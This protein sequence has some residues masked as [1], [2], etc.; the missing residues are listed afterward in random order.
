MIED[1]LECD[2]ASFVDFIE[3]SDNI[4]VCVT[5]TA[6]SRMGPLASDDTGLGNTSSVDIGGPSTESSGSPLKAAQHPN[7]GVA[8]KHP[9]TTERV[10]SQ[11]S[12]RNANGI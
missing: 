4:L 3:V 1:V 2:D 8:A 11:L 12:R 7:Q 9:E 6:M 5:C 10:P